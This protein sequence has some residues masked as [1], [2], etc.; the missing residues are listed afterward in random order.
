M[1]TQTI[2]LSE[3][4]AR[5]ETAFKSGLLKSYGPAAAANPNEPKAPTSWGPAM[6]K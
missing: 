2:A 4:I 5:A 3:K 6:R 1:T